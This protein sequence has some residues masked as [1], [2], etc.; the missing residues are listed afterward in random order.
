[1][2]TIQIRNTVRRLGQRSVMSVVHVKVCNVMAR[3]YYS[4]V[5]FKTLKLTTK[6]VINIIKNRRAKL[7]V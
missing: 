4:Q 6:F 7:L 2:L 5:L 3:E 1:M